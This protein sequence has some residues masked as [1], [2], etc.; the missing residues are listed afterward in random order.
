MNVTGLSPFN[1]MLANVLVFLV[2][3]K[4]TLI[5]TLLFVASVFVGIYMLFDNTVSYLSKNKQDRFVPVVFVGCLFL[6]AVFAGILT[7]ASMCCEYNT[8]T[9]I[10]NNPQVLV[11]SE[12]VL[13]DLSVNFGELKEVKIIKDKGYGLF[14]VLEAQIIFANNEIQYTVGDFK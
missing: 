12:N 13:N 5:V 14:P 10:I 7:H 2:S 6:I 11:N 1:Q 9:K 3:N 4:F 8:A